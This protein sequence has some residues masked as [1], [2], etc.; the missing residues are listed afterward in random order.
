[1]L[2]LLVA[3]AVVQA[4]T[5]EDCLAKK[6]CV[7]AFEAAFGVVNG[8]FMQEVEGALPGRFFP[9]TL[10]W[11][12]V[13]PAGGHFLEVNCVVSGTRQRP[14]PQYQDDMERRFFEAA[15]LQSLPT[16]E[17]KAALFHP[18]TWEVTSEGRRIL[19]KVRKRKKLYEK[20][21]RQAFRQ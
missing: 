4:P 17:P 14:C 13:P 10:V 8:A 6:A 12:L 18:L 5:V 9:G 16:A 15:V 1:M 7:A 3:A 19:E 11:G 21:L 2:A 20:L